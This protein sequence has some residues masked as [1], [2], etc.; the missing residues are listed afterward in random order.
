LFRQCV[1]LDPYVAAHQD[2]LD[3]T[4]LNFSVAREYHE[5]L[6]E[7]YGMKTLLLI[8]CGLM[9][10]G[11]SHAAVYKWVDEGGR[12]NY[13]DSAGDGENQE[14]EIKPGPS[15][16]EMDKAQQIPERKEDY[17]RGAE[18]ETVELS[19]LEAAGPL[20]PNTYTQF[21]ET[22]STN[23]LIDWSKGIAVRFGLL[24]R[25]HSALPKD[26]RYLEAK[27]TNPDNPYAPFVVDQGLKKLQNTVLFVSPLVKS[28]KCQNYE[29]VVKICRRK[30]CNQ[31]I[32][33]VDEHHKL[34]QSRLDTN[35]PLTPERL[36]K[37]L[38]GDGSLCRS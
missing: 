26:A 12:V 37:A 19:A 17:L 2:A 7:S 30:G 4:L 16:E 11:A 28:L 38:S 35:G 24:V 33:G 15:P 27:F 25:I 8:F 31:Q 32:Q 22:I 1:R 29:V 21:L 23:I 34:I 14:L 10:V 9:L 20:P 13:S 5:N 36:V 6:Y 3:T 18:Q